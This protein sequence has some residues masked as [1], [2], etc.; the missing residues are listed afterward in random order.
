ML[1]SFPA[2]ALVGRA[3]DRWG[4][5][6]LLLTSGSLL[7]AGFAWLTFV[8]S[9]AALFVTFLVLSAASGAYDVGI[10]AAAMDLEQA[11]GRRFMAVLHE[12]FSGGGA[13]GALISGA[14][15]LSVWS[16]GTST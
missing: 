16:S 2:M 8:E 10:N 7:G 14:S 6:P 4:H 1:A 15:F 12:A 13:A 9:Y 3:A 11:A 5:R